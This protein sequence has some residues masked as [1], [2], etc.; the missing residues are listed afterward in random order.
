MNTHFYNTQVRWNGERRGTLS[1]PGLQEFAVST[2][3]EFKGEAGFWTPEHL[4][5][6]AAEICLMAT[7]VGIAELSKLSVAGYH[8]EAWG[9]LEKPEGKSLQFTEIVIRPLVVLE[10]LQD[11]PLAERVMTRAEKGCLI[12]N[13]MLTKVRV[14]P[15]FVER[16]SLVA[17]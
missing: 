2:P 1:S 6:A 14:E 9:K 7:F 5:V 4:F 17:A 8:S 15:R 13:S 12:A 11:Q 10:H 16:D 3:P